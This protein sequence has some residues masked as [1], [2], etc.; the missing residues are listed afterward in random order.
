MI[1]IKENTFKENHK[2]CVDFYNHVIG[3][4]IYDYENQSITYNHL[5]TLLNEHFPKNS[6]CYD[7]I[8]NY[9]LNRGVLIG[10]SPTSINGEC[11]TWLAIGI[12]H[13]NILVGN[14][15]YRWEDALDR[16]VQYGF[17]L[18]NKKLLSTK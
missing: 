11:S 2:A 10:F 8:L 15:F 18:L 12:T 6:L 9:F 17:E 4:N 1:A 5:K 16:C 14:D 13:N 3:N 7:F